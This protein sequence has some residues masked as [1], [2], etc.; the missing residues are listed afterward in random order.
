LSARSLN[1]NL[2]IVARADEE[3]FVP[4]LRKAGANEV[5]LT[6][7]IGGMRLASA[8]VRPSVV[9]FLDKMLNMDGA[10]RME[11]ARIEEGAPLIGLS[12]RDARINEKANVLVVAFRDTE[13]EYQFNP[14]SDVPLKSGETL[15]VMAH[16]ENLI[17][18][19][20]LTGGG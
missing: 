19:K 1:P 18:L 5:V 14:P 12:L 13:G 17:A 11:E 8:M 10:L 15:V 16:A 4:K 20:E 6:A 7:K 3:T 9:T 2:R